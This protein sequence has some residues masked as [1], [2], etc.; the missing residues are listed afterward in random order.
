MVQGT[1]VTS[2]MESLQG[3]VSKWFVFDSHSNVIAP[4]YLEPELGVDGD[5]SKCFWESLYSPITTVQR[6]HSILRLAVWRTGN[7]SGCPIL[8]DD[9]KLTV[10]HKTQPPLAPPA[11]LADQFDLSMAPP[12]GPSRSPAVHLFPPTY[13]GGTATPQQHPSLMGG[14]THPRLHVDMGGPAPSQGR[15]YHHPALSRSP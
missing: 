11:V 8:W 2:P 1:S 15:Q 7:N 3:L 5:F 13:T 10:L 6:A 12:A 4:P 9:P 14:G